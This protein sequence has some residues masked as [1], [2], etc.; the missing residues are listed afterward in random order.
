[1]D[2]ELLKIADLVILEIQQ[3]P[4]YKRWIDT[5]RLI[6]LDKDIQSLMS[7]FNQSKSRYEE[8]KKY[9]EY[10][11]N[12]KQ[13][14]SQYQKAKTALFSHPTVIEHKNAEKAVQ[15]VLLTLS[16]NIATSVSTRVPYQTAL[17]SYSEGK[18]CSIEKV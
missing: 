13:Y 4:E 7:A 2:S 15:S 16:K 17:S 11:P 14:R 12:L 18:S 9:G 6:E 8:A 3:M 5:N 10:H 1:M